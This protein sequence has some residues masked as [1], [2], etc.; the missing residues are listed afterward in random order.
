MAGNFIVTTNKF[1]PF[2]YDDFAKPLMMY[3][4]DKQ[5][6]E[7]EYT[8]LGE[9]AALF[10]GLINSE[11]DKEAARIYQSYIDDLKAKRDI[12]YKYGVD[13]L[14]DRDISNMKIGYSSKIKPIELAYTSR[15]EQA[16]KQQEEYNKD[17]S[18]R[19]NREAATTSLDDYLKNPNLN[20]KSISGNKLVAESSAIFSNLAKSVREDPRHWREILGKSYYEA[21]EKSGYNP[22]EIL[23]ALENTEGGQRELNKILEQL[24]KANDIDS[25]DSNIQEYAKENIA[26]GI[27]SAIGQNKY[28]TLDNWRAKME[29]QK[30]QNEKDLPKIQGP[31][32]NPRNYYSSKEKSEYEKAIKEVVDE[33]FI[34]LNPMTKKYEITDKG[35]NIISS[36]FVE[37]DLEDYPFP[38]KE[39][40][41][42]VMSAV[43]FNN[44]IKKEKEKLAAALNIDIDTLGKLDD[45]SLNKALENYGNKYNEAVRDME[46]DTEWLHGIDSSIEDELKKKMLVNHNE[47]FNIID[48]DLKNG[49]YRN[50]GDTISYE[51]FAD[52]KTKLI[53]IVSSSKGLYVEVSI[54]GEKTVKIPL[55]VDINSNALNNAIRN[56]VM[57]K[58]TIERYKKLEEEAI[59]LQNK[60]VNGDNSEETLKKLKEKLYSMQIAENKW[61]EYINSAHSNIGT[62]IS[63]FKTKP[64]EFLPL[65]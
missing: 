9:Q 44:V 60:I 62:F 65:N 38:S 53:N 15:A 30:N 40:P 13:Y 5:K 47:G 22:E 28:T 16:K 59:D 46:K 6:A 12:L 31:Y 49:K 61:N 7:E 21:I 33:G 39:N 63:T 19:F 52:P 14:T 18:I 57:A 3:K 41:D 32:R 37:P 43:A 2:T 36:K 17:S 29:E 64:E 48:F 20:Y 55:D 26:L 35:K 27:W 1:T 51:D 10:E 34:T 24:Y 50:T 23:S 8:K 54:K 11:T 58:D 4:E 25:F 56:H 45:E 42:R